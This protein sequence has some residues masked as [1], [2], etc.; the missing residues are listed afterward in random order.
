GERKH[1]PEAVIVKEAAE[2]KQ[3]PVS[4]TRPPRGLDVERVRRQ[5]VALDA[6]VEIPP[7][8]VRPVDDQVERHPTQIDASPP[9]EVPPLPNNQAEVEVPPG[10]GQGDQGESPGRKPPP[11]Q[12]ERKPQRYKEGKELGLEPSRSPACIGTA[13]AEQQGRDQVP[14]R[15]AAD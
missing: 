1:E 7:G 12:V 14:C 10:W 2:V 4:R 15:V 9:A 8:E 3:A 5:P 11:R 13:Q 6:V